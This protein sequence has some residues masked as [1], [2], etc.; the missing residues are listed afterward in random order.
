MRTAEFIDTNLENEFKRNGYVHLKNFISPEQVEELMFLFKSHYDYAGQPNPLWNSLCDIDHKVSATLSDR[1]LHVLRNNIQATFKNH[2]YPAA[3]FLVKNATENSSIDIHRDY[4]VHEEDKFSYRN[5]WLPIVDTTSENGALYVVK[6]SHRFF[7]YPLPHYTPWPYL[8]HEKLLLEVSDI[9]YAKAG[10]L[11]VYDDKILHGSLDNNT[12][13]A[14][15]VVH[16]GLLHEDAQLCYYYHDQET[17]DVTVYEVPYTF[18]FEGA[19]G[20][21]DHRFKIVKKFKFVPPAFSEN[22][23]LDGLSK[24]LAAV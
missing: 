6:G 9:I 13:N 12:S 10:D 7:T 22:E 11:I 17:D 5:I 18:F 19:W 24:T 14:R 1:I 20:N 23:I 3:T 8:K 15:P 4:S 2:K 21:Q 16:F